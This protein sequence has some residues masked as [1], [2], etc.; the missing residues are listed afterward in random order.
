MQWF[1]K[2]R[3]GRIRCLAL[4]FLTY[5]AAQSLLRAVNLLTSLDMVSLA[6]GDMLRTFLAGLVYDTASGVFFTLP[7]ALLL[8]GLPARWLNRKVGRALLFLVTF[9]QNGL[10]VFSLVAL[11]LYWQEFHTNFNFIAVDYLVY[12]QEMIGQIR[13]SFPVEILLPGIFA[14]ALALTGWEGSRFPCVFPEK[15]KRSC[16]MGALCLLLVPLLAVLVPQD[17]WREKS[18]TM[19]TTWNWQETVP[20][21]SSTRTSITSW[22][23]TGITGKKTGISSARICGRPCVRTMSRLPALSTRST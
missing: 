5:M 21:V 17:T 3:Q 22:I 12:T 7:L 9:F 13:Q 10:M 16:L 23:T 11:H 8:W 18:V 1:D 6:A 20:T 2:M 15:G 19:P 4:F 14:V